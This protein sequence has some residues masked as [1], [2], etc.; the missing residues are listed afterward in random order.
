MS[1]IHKLKTLLTD[2]RDK[3]QRRRWHARCLVCSKWQVRNLRHRRYAQRRVDNHIWNMHGVD[4]ARI[5]PIRALYR[6][7]A[8]RA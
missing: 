2:L 7:W 5:H 6:I 3:I 8:T 4:S 1:A